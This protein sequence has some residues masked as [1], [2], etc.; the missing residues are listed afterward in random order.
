MAT[1]P[2]SCR[3]FLY[4]GKYRIRIT[5]T[6]ETLSG[7]RLIDVSQS[8]AIEFDPDTSAK[9]NA[10][11]VL[12]ITGPIMMIAGVA[13]LLGHPNDYERE[14]DRTRINVGAFLLLGGLAATPIG[15]VMFGT[16][17]K[18]EYEIR[19]WNAGPSPSWSMGPG[20]TGSGVGWVGSGSF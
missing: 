13:T 15:W 8:M 3:L 19:T 1:C 10:G 12:G 7:S 18:P 17:F 20:V 9:K 14:E 4:P 2:S 5:E 11:L 6:D 16:S